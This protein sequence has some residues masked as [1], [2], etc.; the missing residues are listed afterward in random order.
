MFSA[1]KCSILTLSILLGFLRLFQQSSATLWLSQCFWGPWFLFSTKPVQHFDFR[2]IFWVFGFL[3]QQTSATFWLSQYCGAPWR[4]L[5]TEE[6]SAINLPL[7]SSPLR[8]CDHIALIVPVFNDF[9][10]LKIVQSYITSSRISSSLWK[11]V[12]LLCLPNSI[13][14]HKRTF[15]AYFFLFSKGSSQKIVFLGLFPE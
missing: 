11:Y 8:I 13:Q 1:N 10:C 3:S 2:N 15:L 14:Y 5:S 9:G 7:R 6:G 4:S 12:Y